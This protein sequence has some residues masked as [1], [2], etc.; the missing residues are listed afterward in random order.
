MNEETIPGA[1]LRMVFSASG[2]V[3]VN[4]HIF[5][6]GDQFLKNLSIPIMSPGWYTTVE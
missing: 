3:L 4:R 2:E 5:P 6:Q 1:V